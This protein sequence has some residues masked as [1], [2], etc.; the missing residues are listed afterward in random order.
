MNEHLREKWDGCTLWN[1]LDQNWTGT[2]WR[3]LLWKEPTLRSHPKIR[4]PGWALQWSVPSR[5]SCHRSVLKDGQVS[6]TEKDD[7]STLK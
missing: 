4:L 5:L 6:K 3:W 2:Q 7:D 1:C